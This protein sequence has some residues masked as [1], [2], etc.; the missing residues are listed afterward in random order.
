PRRPTSARNRGRPLP[1]TTW[2]P[3]IR[4]SKGS[5]AE[6]MRGIHGRGELRVVQ[7]RVA[8]IIRMEV[9][10]NRSFSLSLLWRGVGVCVWRAQ[11]NP[12]CN[13][14]PSPPTPL[15]PVQR[16]GEEEG[17]RHESEEEA[18]LLRVSAPVGDGGH[19]DRHP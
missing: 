4:T 12:F 8:A 1:S 16:R 7:S 10:G 2:P 6:C 13:L 19:R 17:S 3:V 11:C 14:S 15:P 18:L 9:S 5:T